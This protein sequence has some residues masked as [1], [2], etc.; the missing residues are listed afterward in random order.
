MSAFSDAVNL[1]TFL[2]LPLS[3]R[4]AFSQVGSRGAPSDG[5][6]LEPRTP[7]LP[8][9]PDGAPFDRIP[10]RPHVGLRCCGRPRP[11]D[12][13]IARISKSSRRGSAPTFQF[14]KAMLQPC[15]G[16]AIKAALWGGG[17]KP[18]RPEGLICAFAFFSFHM[19]RGFDWGTKAVWGRVSN[20]SAGRRRRS[21]PDFLIGGRGLHRE[22]EFGEE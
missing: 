14:C 21:K 6:L 8:Q 15:R 7:H 13:S 18:T 12:F 22:G 3:L 16:R 17:G 2:S 19:A 9:D 11:R 1:S 4:T 10:E 5:P 20:E